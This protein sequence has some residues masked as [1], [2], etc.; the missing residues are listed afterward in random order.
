MRPG[1]LA[2]FFGLGARRASLRASPE[3]L[4]LWYAVAEIGA[5][6]GIDLDAMAEHVVERIERNGEHERAILL[7]LVRL[8]TTGDLCPCP[9]VQYTA[10]GRLRCQ[11]PAGHAPPHRP[12]VSG[13][14]WIQG[15]ER[16][17]YDLEAARVLGALSV[18]ALAAIREAHGRPLPAADALPP[19]L[20]KEMRAAA[21]PA[22]PRQEEES[23]G[24]DDT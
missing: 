1:A 11:L 3:D 6:L 23:D 22:P 24:E 12:E 14:A 16:P 2:R 13:L 17:C 9:F 18:L 20:T 10:T 5:A 15:G 8:A 19:W 7:E 4:E 21:I